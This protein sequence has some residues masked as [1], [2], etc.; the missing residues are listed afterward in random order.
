MKANCARLKSS[1]MLLIVSIF[2]FSGGQ[3]WAQNSTL[4]FEKAT[5][6]TKF[7]KHVRWP[8]EARQ[9]ALVIGVYNDV[10]KYEYFSD[11][12]A[13]K[14][15]KDKDII[16]RLV[17]EVDEAKDVN[18]LY[19]SASSSSKRNTSVLA[20]KISGSHVL[21]IT[22]DNKSNSE[23][24]VDITYN[25]QI[26]NM[27]FEVSYPNIIDEKLFM[28]E[29]SYFM[30]EK[31]NQNILS[32]SP[33]FL[34]KSQQEQ[35]LIE[36]KALEAKVAKQQILLDQLSNKLKVSEES[37]E[38]YNFVLEKHS[39]RLK[40][41]QQSNVTKNKEIEVIT[42]KIKRLE[43]Q[44]Q[45]QKLQLTMNKQDLPVVD[46]EKIKEQEQII[47]GLTADLKKQKQ[48]TNN[49]AI[50]LT[51]MTQDNNNLSSYKMLF[52]VFLIMLV[53]ALIIVYIMWN[54]AKTAKLNNVLSLNNEDD[55]MLSVR[56]RQLMKSENVAALG[57]IATD[58]TYAINLS[59]DDLMGQLTS[60]DDI[61][62]VKI[63][64]PVV[65]LLEN[66]NLIA[67]DQDETHI[68]HF[69][70][71]AYAQKMMML[72]EFEFNQSEIVY[73]Y[74]GEKE[75]MI[76]SVP[77]YIAL[78]LLNVINNSLKHG[79][80]NNGK[81]KIALKIEKGAKS[82]AKIT[83]I[84]DGKGMSKGTLEQV[85]KPFFTTC[86]DRDY[87]GI[88][89]STTYDLIKNKLAGDIKIMSQE[90]KG[91]SVIITLP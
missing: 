67:A 75:L 59:L 14:G 37:S 63:L 43:K 36:R 48:I 51:N 84:D 46:D 16:I 44:L 65:K 72:Y 2:I 15:I 1:F 8:V 25:K 85:F 42:A 39:E 12:F 58:L 23:I 91:T 90:G 54:K 83:Y 89:M 64:K 27:T 47:M 32:A 62:K 52:Y 56:E 30:D 6:V 5:L 38:K 41:A 73:S 11:F 22:E 45:D 18:I 71:I 88:G 69:D 20:N 68:Q 7:L 66:F 77:S 21:L 33:S 78:A 57:Y 74:S 53:I 79:F 28:P 3:T 49:T 9:S 19:I 76:K 10:D 55:L 60:A 70:L 17:T 80:D 86:S 40:I 50:K 13:D 24:M 87:V 81:G 35:Q 61:N 26:S 82:G 29:L 34:L 31:N 4:D